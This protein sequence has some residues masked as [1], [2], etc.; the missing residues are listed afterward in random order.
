[1]KLSIKKIFVL[2]IVGAVL[3]GGLVMT[4]YKVFAIQGT[5]HLSVQLSPDNGGRVIGK[6][7]YGSKIID[8]G[9]NSN[10]VCDADIVNGNVKVTLQIQEIADG[11]LFSSWGGA[12]SVNPRDQNYCIL[13]WSAGDTSDKTVTVNFTYLPNNLNVILQSDDGASS[14][15]GIVETTNASA[16]VQNINCGMGNTQC[17]TLLLFK[18]NITLKSAAANYYQFSKW[19]GSGIASNCDRQTNLTCKVLNDQSD[20]ATGT[21]IANFI[22]SKRY[23]EV[24]PTINRNANSSGGLITG[25][26]DNGTKIINCG[27]DSNNSLKTQCKSRIDVGPVTVTLT[28]TP[29]SGYK[30]SGWG[31]DCSTT[32]PDQDCVLSWTKG[33]THY[34]YVTADF[35][36]QQSPPPPP[37]PSQYNLQVALAYYGNSGKIVSSSTIGTITTVGSSK[38]VTHIDCGYDTTQQCGTYLT[39]GYYSYT[40]NIPTYISPQNI[41]LLV[42]TSSG[43]TFDHWKWEQVTGLKPKSSC[44]G[45]TST[46]C[47]FVQADSAQSPNDYASGTLIAIFTP[48]PPK[49]EGSATASLVYVSSSASVATVY[50][51]WPA[52]KDDYFGGSYIVKRINV[53]TGSST[54]VTTT[55][56]TY[57]YDT[58]APLNTTSSYNVS[59]QSKNS[60]VSSTEVT[61]NPVNLN[62]KNRLVEY[63]WANIGGTTTTGSFTPPSPGTFSVTGS[64]SANSV[65]INVQN[66]GGNCD[67]WNAKIDRSSGNQNW[68]RE[69]T[70]SELSPDAQ[71]SWTDKP[72]DSDTTFDYRI[73]DCLLY[74][75]PSP[76]D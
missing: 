70:T 69:I 51:S 32:K 11:Y 49:L 36:P 71:Y 28:S 3:S 67:S 16:N 29:A 68:V 48:I 44:D 13:S 61:S 43:Y 52:V 20:T 42:S 76:R 75:S 62:I 73:I 31:G 27:T 65:T 40:H 5:R 33:D 55:Q 34:S 66:S 72:L 74:T 24:T 39:G 59:F 4:F 63:A 58:E 56:N 23:I 22:R 9:I 26:E 53:D 38:G 7:D 64:A 2:L 37:P 41:S 60:L 6:T 19:S 30:F 8:C 46:V 18:D 10:D 50:V 1:M 45:E 57:F 14:S 35:T 47:Q 12:C 17:S 25:S 15:A 21:L 54:V